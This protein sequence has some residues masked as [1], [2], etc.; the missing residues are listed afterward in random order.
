MEQ[1]EAVLETVELTS[2]STNSSE[3]DSIQAG[4]DTNSEQISGSQILLLIGA[5]FICTFF[6]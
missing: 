4:V 3:Q 6:H 2:F 5:A 1:M